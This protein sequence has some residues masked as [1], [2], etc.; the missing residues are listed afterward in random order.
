M[1]RKTWTERLNDPRPFEVKPAPSDIAGMKRGQ[2]MLIPTARLVDTF[3]RQI[4]PGEH[5]DVPTLRQ[6]M[7]AAHQAQ[8]TCPITTGFHLRTVAEAAFE[9]LND[10]E[11]LEAVT[12]FWRVLDEHTPTA[13]RL[14]FGTDLIR[15]QREREGL[16]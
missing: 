15:A 10:G 9:S 13:R 6:R 2:I 16:V 7:A 11:A 1:K 14:S 3:V 8:V 5:I 12:P 4:P